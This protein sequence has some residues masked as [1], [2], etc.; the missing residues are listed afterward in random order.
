MGY[1]YINSNLENLGLN[2]NR[3]GYSFKLCPYSTAYRDKYTYDDSYYSGFGVDGSPVVSTNTIVFGN[4]TN[5][6]LQAL[7]YAGYLCSEHTT[8]SG[9]MVY[10]S[11]PPGWICK[12]PNCYY[13]TTLVSGCWYYEL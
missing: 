1:A 8:T 13:H 3:R 11:S 9:R 5:S 7:G 10:H 12:D 6:G 2:R 4:T